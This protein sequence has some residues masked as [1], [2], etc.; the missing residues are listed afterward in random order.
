M[1]A[2]GIDSMSSLTAFVRAAETRS[3]VAAGRILG[4]SSSAVGKSVAR[5][6]EKLGV[7]LLHRST[8]SIHL[9]AEGALF[10]ERCQRV[11]ADL[12]DAEAELLRT[13]EAPRGRLRVS[14]PAVGYRLLSPVLPAFTRRYP[15]VELDIDYNDRM[16]DVIE[17]G[18]DAVLRTGELADSRLMSRRLGAYRFLIVASPNY[19]RRRRAPQSPR[20]LSRHACLF[21]KIP[22]TGKIQPWAFEADGEDETARLHSVMTC[23]SV[24]ALIMAARQGLGLA[25]LPDFAVRDEL[26]QKALLALLPDFPAVSGTFRLLWPANRLLSPKVRVFAE[27]LGEHTSL[28]RPSQLKRRRPASMPTRK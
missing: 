10:F 6:E 20:D 8:R 4:V 1:S 21:Y 14:L 16:V 23:N 2:I 3:Y 5:L 17:E 19:V 18:F 15:E 13:K 25:Y 28:Q 26:A 27:F 9:T 12:G 22:T 7:L 11:L 24:E